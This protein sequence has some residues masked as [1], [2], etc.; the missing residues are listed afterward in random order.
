MALLRKV[1]VLGV[2][3]KQRQLLKTLLVFLLSNITPTFTDPTICVNRHTGAEVWMAAMLH[4]LTKQ[5]ILWTVL[6]FLRR[7]Q[8]TLRRIAL[9]HL[10]ILCVP[11]RLG[12]FPSLTVKERSR[13]YYV[14]SVLLALTCPVVHPPVTV[15]TIESLSLFERRILQGMLDTSR[16]RMVPLRVLRTR[17]AEDWSL[18][19]PLPLLPHLT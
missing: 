3:R 12:V 6:S 7:A 5:T 15:E 1:W 18:V 17:W 4:A 10:V 19:R 8:P 2:P 9:T 11:T 16:W 13:G 14:L